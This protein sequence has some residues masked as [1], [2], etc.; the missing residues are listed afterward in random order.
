MPDTKKL[1]DLVSSVYSVPGNPNGWNIFLP[2]ATEFVGGKTSAYM[3]LDDNVMQVP[4]VYGYSRDELQELYEGD[5]A[6]HKDVRVKYRGN[7]IPGR[8]FREFE[9][10]PD[11]Q[12]HDSCEWIQY[13]LKMRGVYWN[14]I[15]QI[16][17]HNLWQDIISFNRVKTAGPYSDE[18]KA[19]LQ[20]MLPHMSRAA[21][22]HRTFTRME[23]RFGAVLAVLDKLLVG[24]II[25]DTKG[26]VALINASASRSVD[27]TGALSLRADSTLHVTDSVVDATLQKLTAATAETIDA[28]GVSEGGQISVPTRSIGEDLLLEIM[29]IRDDGLPDSDNIRGVAV[30]VIDPNRAHILNTEALSTI[31]SLSPA[32]GSIASALVNGAKPREIAEERNTTFETVRSQVKSIYHKTGARSEGDLVRLA[33][34]AN[35]PIARVSDEQS[36]E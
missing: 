20:T 17:T 6:T 1:L 27:D 26:R 24:L 22:L 2:E 11:K 23:E 7:L 31:F 34:K 32:E 33:A 29:P 28:A 18:E 8:V 21:E 14:L 19:A 25:L 4:A 9:Y 30:F 10:V 5:T 3:M 13:D 16:S 12:A 15:A 35:P 36:D